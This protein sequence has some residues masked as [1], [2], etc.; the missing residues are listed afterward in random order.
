MR[1][2]VGLLLLGSLAFGQD[3]D[4]GNKGKRAKYR[5]H[6][7]LDSSFP[8]EVTLK[9]SDLRE[10][11]LRRDH[12]LFKPSMTSVICVC[13]LPKTCNTNWLQWKGTRVVIPANDYYGVFLD[14]FLKVPE[15]V[16][17][18]GI[19]GTKTFNLTHETLGKKK[20]YSSFLATRNTQ[21]EIVRVDGKFIKFTASKRVV[22]KSYRPDNADEETETSKELGPRFVR[23][24]IDFPTEGREYVKLD[25]FLLSFNGSRRKGS[26]YYIDWGNLLWSLDGGPWVTLPIENVFHMPRE[27]DFVE[28]EATSRPVWWYVSAK[29]LRSKKHNPA[30]HK[31]CYE[32]TSGC[33]KS[34]RRKS[35]SRVYRPPQRRCGYI[36]SKMQKRLRSRERSCRRRVYRRATSERANYAC[37][38]RR[39]TSER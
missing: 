12:S 33:E 37:G 26:S 31:N 25:I 28:G 35:K 34:P 11:W 9:E 17:R 1:W 5:P 23:N 16:K 15:G 21:T 10:G 14:G 4:I 20:S 30:K 38:R 36:P 13:I 3:Y 27:D 8:R 22:G 39:A 7:W 19:R 32:E 18:I 2:L 24:Y 6:L 29:K